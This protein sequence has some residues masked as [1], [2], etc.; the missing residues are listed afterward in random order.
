MPPP[1]RSHVFEKK[2]AVY[3][4]SNAGDSDHAPGHYFAIASVN[5]SLGTD[6]FTGQC[7]QYHL[8][9]IEKFSRLSLDRS[10]PPWQ[11]TPPSP[12]ACLSHDLGDEELAVQVSESGASPNGAS[13]DGVAEHTAQLTPITERYEL[14]DWIA[15]TIHST[16]PVRLQAEVLLV[17]PTRLKF[18]LPLLQSHRL[19]CLGTKMKT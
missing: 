2:K 6:A 18:L 11:A 1:P 7:Q 10:S 19:P 9:R 12:L 8:G 15:N 5:V 14:L 16:P 13:P 4:S 3:T 17:T